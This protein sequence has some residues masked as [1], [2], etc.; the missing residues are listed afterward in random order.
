M[1]TK[2]SRR[3]PICGQVYTEPPALSRADNKTEICPP[4]GAREALLQFRVYML[5]EAGASAQVCR[6]IRGQINHGDLDGAAKGIQQVEKRM[7]YQKGLAQDG[8]MG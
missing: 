7:G 2:E 4:C 1:R 5:G 6:T 3:C 8:T